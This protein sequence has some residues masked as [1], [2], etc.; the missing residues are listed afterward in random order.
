MTATSEA[1]ANV[2]GRLGVC[3]KQGDALLEVQQNQQ[4]LQSEQVLHT[5]RLERNGMGFI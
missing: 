3:E 5:E 4:Q 1:L 2:N